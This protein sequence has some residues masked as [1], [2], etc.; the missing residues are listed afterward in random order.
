MRLFDAYFIYI[1]IISSIFSTFA[2]SW[3]IGQLSE[4]RVSTAKRK[5]M[6]IIFWL[7]NGHAKITH[8]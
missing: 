3:P 6:S 1:Y 5:E 2:W 7:E 4:S 8:D